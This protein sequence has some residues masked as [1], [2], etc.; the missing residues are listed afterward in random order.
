M[1]WAEAYLHNK[2]HLDLSSRL[3]TTEM[4]QK[5][6]LCPI[7][8]G[9]WVPIQHNVAGTQAYLHAKFHLHPFNRLATIHQRHRQDNGSVAR[10]E[11]LLVIVAQKLQVCCAWIELVDEL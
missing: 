11:L 10:G 1:A 7:F 4:G 6:G 5:W 9:S 3:A 2:W 8:G